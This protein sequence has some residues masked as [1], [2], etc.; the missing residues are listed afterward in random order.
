[1]S[2]QPIA[3]LRNIAKTFGTGPGA[4]RV[5]DGVDLEFRSG[6]LA[7]LEGPSGSGK[8]TL[9][10]ILGCILKPSAGSVTIRD[11]EVTGLSE[12]QLPAVRL[13]H[14]GFVFQS[15]NL[16]PALSA[17]ENVQMPLALQR[18]PKRQAER[19]AAELLENV[20]LASKARALPRDLSGG[21][22]QRVAVA[23]ALASSPDLLLADE[24]TAA[25]DWT[26]GRGVMDL[27]RTFGR[28]H[29]RAV[30]VVSHDPRLTEFAD[31]VIGLRDGRLA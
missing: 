20:G 24:P 10:S 23:R 27:L 14:V 19:R 26:A 3:A 7:L 12:Q 21:E 8:T 31:R 9:L 28:R 15:F 4:L 22:Q 6:E 11:R 5:L 29:D 18:V 30:V 1:M 17:H 16:L 13:R 2:D 25:L